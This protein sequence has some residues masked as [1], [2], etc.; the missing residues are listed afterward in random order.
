MRTMN[1]NEAILKV[2]ETNVKNKVS[3]EPFPQL[4]NPNIG[5]YLVDTESDVAK[6]KYRLHLASRDLTLQEVRDVEQ[7]LETKLLIG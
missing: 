2:V 4:K 1:Y 6:L 5:T 7:K 3:T